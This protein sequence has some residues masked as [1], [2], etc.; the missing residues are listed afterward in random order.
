VEVHINSLKISFISMIFPNRLLRSDL[1]EI[2]NKILIFWSLWRHKIKIILKAPQK[3]I[4]IS[5]KR[6]INCK[7]LKETVNF[8]K[9]PVKC[10][11]LSLILNFLL[12]K[13]FTKTSPK[14]LNEKIKWMNI[15]RIKNNSFL[16]FS[17]GL[18]RKNLKIKINNSN[19]RN[20]TKKSIKKLLFLR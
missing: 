10:K 8:R 1:A 6:N 19:K 7:V 4:F 16:I 9:H 12:I 18:I 20:V 5:K 11:R 15:F 3:I 17:K 14:Q 2:K 13:T